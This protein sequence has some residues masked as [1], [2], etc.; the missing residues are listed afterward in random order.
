M[1]GSQ[2]HGQ[3][4]MSGQKDLKL[5]SNARNTR[6]T[7]E[8]QYFLGGHVEEPRKCGENF[9]RGTL[10]VTLIRTEGRPAHPDESGGIHL[11]DA[12]GCENWHREGRH[13]VGD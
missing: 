13:W 7:V 5:W 3:T 9:D 10:Y 4:I 6:G 1:N 11:V 2:I 8:D 12:E